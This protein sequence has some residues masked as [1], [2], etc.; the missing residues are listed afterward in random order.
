MTATFAA[1][2]AAH[3][4]ADFVFQTGGMVR[5]KRRP[6]VLVLHGAI[7]FATAFAL[8]GPAA[9]L[10]LLALAVAHVGIDI[11]K[12]RVPARGAGP[13]L[14]DQGAHLV[15]LVLLALLAPGLWAA[16]PWAALPDP[17]AA[18]LLHTLVLV[19]GFIVATRAGGFAIGLLMS[20]PN[21]APPTAGLADGGRIIGLLERGL[22]FLLILAGQYDAIGFLIAAK[23]ILRFG[24]V[25]DDRAVSEYVIIGTLASFGWAIAAGLGTVELLATLPPL[26]I[27]PPAP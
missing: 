25:G 23:S 12:L 5:H 10:P 22:I 13:F 21:W 26:A 19:A 3:V 4:F 18:L 15:S 6:G 8:L 24:T 27:S 11:V 20:A 2:L 1:L 7:V 9:T 16:S 14:A 17:G